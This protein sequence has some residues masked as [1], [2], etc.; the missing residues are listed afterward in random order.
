MDEP[1]AGNPLS[2]GGLPD[3]WLRETEMSET[4]HTLTALYREPAA[5][6]RAVERLRAIGV[7][8]H[9]IE[10]FPDASGDVRPGEHIVEGG[11]LGSLSNLLTPERD[12]HHPA[13]TSAVLI[14]SHVPADQLDA[15]RTALREEAIEL[16]D[17][18]PDKVTG[19]PQDA[20]R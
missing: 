9:H 6:E 5:A 16:D 4:T 19:R 20:K 13:T 7:P 14:A 2:V 17:N 15:A 1:P 3:Q 18:G 8:E 12:L 10:H 11:L